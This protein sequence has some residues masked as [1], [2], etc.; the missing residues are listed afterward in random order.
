MSD[1]SKY[2]NI[3]VDSETEPADEKLVTKSNTSEDNEAQTRDDLSNIYETENPDNTLPIDEENIET[4]ALTLDEIK[5]FCDRMSGNNAV[6]HSK[7]VISY[8]SY[9]TNELGQF[10]PEA[11]QIYQLLTASAEF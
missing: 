5:S 1:F 3:E 8:Q 2:F 7:A 6:G 11:D 4:K 9:K 10:S